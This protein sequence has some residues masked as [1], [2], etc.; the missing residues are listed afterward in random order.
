MTPTPKR[1]RRAPF[2]PGFESLAAR[3]AIA[4][5]LMVLLH[6]QALMPLSAAPAPAAFRMALPER[7][8][9]ASPAQPQPAA[10]DAW[11]VELKA[12]STPF[13]DIIGIDHHQ[14]SNKLVLSVNHPSGQPGNFEL[15][16]PDG[17]HLS[18]SNIAGFTGQLKIAAARDDGQGASLGGFKPGEL[19]TGTGVPGVI[20]RIAANGS[21]VQNPWVTLPGETGQLDGGLYLDRTGSFGGD[22]VAVTTQGGVWRINSAGTPT[23][24]ASLGARLEG[25]T[26]VPNDADRYGPWAGKILAGAPEQGTIYAVDQQGGSTAYGLGINPEEIRVIPAHENFYGVDA[27]SRKLWGAPAAAFSGMIGDVL[28]AQGSPG[29]LARV[30][31]NGAQFEVSEIAQAT[32]WKQFTFSPAGV[33]EIPAVKQAYD[34]IA[35]VRH[36]PVINSGRVEGSLWQLTGENVVLDGRDVITTD[37]LVPGTPTVSV[38]DN[39]TFSGTIQ[40]VEN[41]QPG[42]YGVALSGNA[43]LRHLI[44]RTNPIQLQPVAAPPLPQGTREVAL[45]RAGE[46]AGDFATLRHLSLSGKAGAVSVPPGTYGKFNASGHTAF[47]FGVVNS[48]QPTVYNLE[49]LTLSGGSELRLAGPVVITVKNNVVLSGSTVGA[50]EDPR[51]VTLNIAAGELRVSGNSVL[52][53]V[54]RAPASA[55]TIE[56]GGRLRGTVSC[57]RLTVNGNGVLQITESDLPPPPSTARP[58][59]KPGRTRRSRSRPTP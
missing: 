1:S 27:G 53:G 22:L 40:G 54:V 9:A 13:D 48:A 49:E 44:T 46:S 55:V 24:L 6:T 32:E 5:L 10:P 35:I 31:W 38:S 28:V 59:P 36:A 23:L 45:T 19:F 15:I 52:Y 58:R 4:C 2:I 34:K 56:G 37:L 18:Y 39:P 26:T 43:T 3:R 33:A 57:D 12:V 30:R 21:T 17:A 41:P 20:A 50:A 16:E 25:V 8:A 42:G 29:V 11:G 47:V 51:R 14:P 7:V